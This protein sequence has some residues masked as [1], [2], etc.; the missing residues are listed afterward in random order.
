MIMMGKSDRHM[1][2]NFADS[3]LNTSGLGCLGYN[4][5]LWCYNGRQ[6]QSSIQGSDRR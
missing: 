4:D 1:W 6:E 2:V 5:K 3:D